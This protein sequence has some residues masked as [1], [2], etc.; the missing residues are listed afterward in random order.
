[1]RR[2]TALGAGIAVAALFFAGFWELAQVYPTSP[3]ILAFDAA[4]TSA[5]QSFRGPVLTR[6]MVVITVLGATPSVVV[7]VVA[8]GVGL[9]RRGRH[10]DTYYAMAVAAGGALLSTFAKGVYGRPRPPA[11]NALVDLPA[12]F[13]F[14]SGHTMGSLCLGWALGYAI[15]S[16]RSMRPSLKPLLLVF[17]VLYPVLVGISRVYLGVHWPSDVLASWL[18]G[19]AWIALASGVF[20]AVRPPLEPLT[21]AAR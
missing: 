16:S 7:G 14:P 3:A 18:L 10:P 8:L 1:M 6:V 20:A 15:V 11:A 17:A 2:P 4:V 21:R 13:S 5:I 9:A 12:S 19:A